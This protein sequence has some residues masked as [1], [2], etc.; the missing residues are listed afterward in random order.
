MLVDKDGDDGGSMLLG[1]GE[2]QGGIAY[3]TVALI[4]LMDETTFVTTS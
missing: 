4:S 3:T 1:M 2:G